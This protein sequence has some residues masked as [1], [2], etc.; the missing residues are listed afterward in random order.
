[1][2]CHICNKELEKITKGDINLYMC[3]VCEGI[4]VKDKDL[5]NI[6]LKTRKI[7]RKDGAL[8]PIKVDVMKYA[9]QKVPLSKCPNCRYNLYVIESKGLELDHCLNCKIFWFDKGELAA[10]IERYKNGKAIVLESSEYTNDSVINL[11][12]SL[13]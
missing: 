10:L 1:M 9:R 11:I 3:P 8:P 12:F 13:K 2:K 6:I 5:Q 7:V 4:A